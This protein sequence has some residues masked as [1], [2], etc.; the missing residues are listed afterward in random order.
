MIGT[1]NALK[2]YIETLPD[3]ATKYVV[4]PYKEKRSKDANSYFHVL[5]E[6]MRLELGLSMARMKNQLVAR[7]GEMLKDKDGDQVVYKT[8]MPPE[9]ALE[10]EEPHLW[11]VRS[12]VENG[13]EVYFYRVYDRTRDYNG[14]QM[15]RL[16]DGTV[17][18]CKEM[19][20]ETLSPDKIAHLNAMWEQKH[21]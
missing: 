10:Q 2:A 7:Y 14:K 15:A 12:D 9:Y 5:A 6:K 19:G 21:G 4:E 3:D 18:E 17:S 11:L 8:N 20:I 16:I 13:K 1:K